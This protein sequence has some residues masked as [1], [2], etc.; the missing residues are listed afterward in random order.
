MVFYNSDFALGFILHRHD[1]D[2]ASA[3]FSVNTTCSLILKSLEA[4]AVANLPLG[5]ITD[6]IHFQ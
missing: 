1:A 6:R 4:T 3:R 5:E 2:L